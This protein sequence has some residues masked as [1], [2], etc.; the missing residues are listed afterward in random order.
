MSRQDGWT[1]VRYGKRRGPPRHFEGARGTGPPRRKDRAPPVSYGRQVHFPRPNRPVPPLGAARYLGPQSRS[2][3][4]VTRQNISR[5]TFASRLTFREF[6]QERQQPTDK[7]FGLL[8]RKMHSIIKMVHH[9]QNV[10]PKPGK[11]EPKMISHMVETLT[12]MIKPASPN[13]AT[14]DLIMGNAKNWGY[15]TLV[16]LEDHYKASLETMLADLSQDLIPEWKPAFQVATKW[17]KRNLP[18][19]MQDVFDHAEAL[20]MSCQEGD[21]VIN[22]QCQSPL[23]QDGPVGSTQV[24]QQ[25]QETPHTSQQ[26]PQASPNPHTS[27]E[28]TKTTVPKTKTTSQQTST[29]HDVATMTEVIEQWSLDQ[30]EEQQSL[31]HRQQTSPKVQRWRRGIVTNSCV[32]SEDSFSF[33]IEGDDRVSQ[34]SRHSNRGWEISP[35]RDSSNLGMVNEQDSPL[36]QSPSSSTTPSRG[37]NQEDQRHE[38]LIHQTPSLGFETSGSSSSE[39]S[40]ST[41][42]APVF[43]V[44]RHPHSERK[45]IDWGLGVAKKWLII[46]DSNLS[47]FPGYSIPD[48][49]IESYPGANFRHAQ[50]LM[51][52]STSQ[53]VVEK[54]VLA[55]GINSRGVRAKETSIRQMQG[56]VRTAKKIF[57]YSEI[58][59]P[60]I[61]YSTYLSTAEQTSLRVLNLHIC[62]NMPSIPALKANR[63]NTERDH[64]HWTAETAKAMLDHWVRFLNLIPQEV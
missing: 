19:I 57:P 40:T 44:K 63:F 52:K 47:R 42:R 58:W 23:P 59:I 50:A 30:D 2:Y 43:R 3:A 46:G 20:I 5:G 26:T 22:R 12:S 35:S 7:A 14:L 25:T 32:V 15:N 39:A 18:R 8:V 16:I 24:S 10:A 64:V 56:A 48:L 49:Q 45:M 31:Q 29:N 62:K 4:A 21:V 9:L 33:E 61:N 51:A 11:S 13:S 55:F 17:A 53:V 34:G 6:R 54:I 41:P 37:D 27:T 60:V 36:S 38:V 28:R 1:V